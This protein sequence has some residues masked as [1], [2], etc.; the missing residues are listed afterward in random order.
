[1]F[2]NKISLCSNKTKKRLKRD[3]IISISL[4]LIGFAVGYYYKTAFIIAASM[5][6]S[7]IATYLKT[8]ECKKYFV[9]LDGQKLMIRTPHNSFLEIPLSAVSKIDYFP[10]MLEI[11]LKNGDFKRIII[12]D[13]DEEQK[14]QINNL[15]NHIS[16]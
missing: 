11:Y 1:M 7:L 3:Y 10:N 9:K 5:S 13:F 12:K 4:I 16:I 2:Q 14:T 8:R 15:I 6:G